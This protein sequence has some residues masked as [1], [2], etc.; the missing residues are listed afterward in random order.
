MKFDMAPAIWHR[1]RN[2]A[3]RGV[4][5]RHSVPR[6]PC[7][8]GNHRWRRVHRDRYTCA[9]VF[10]RSVIILNRRTALRAALGAAITVLGTSACGQKGPLYSPEEKLDEPERK[11]A[12]KA[13]K[14]I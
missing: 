2:G 14:K 8:A 13:R 9:L 4:Y 1:R 11:R 3:R 5:T 6:W 7:A 10:R 12:E